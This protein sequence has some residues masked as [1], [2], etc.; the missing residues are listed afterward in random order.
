MGISISVKKQIC[1]LVDEGLPYE[2]IR[3]K[4]KLKSASNISM[5]YKQK[6]RWIKEFES[7]G[8]L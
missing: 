4:F 8:H 7:D 2:E 5:I 6:E 3:T 1:D